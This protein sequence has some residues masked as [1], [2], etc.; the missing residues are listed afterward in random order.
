MTWRGGLYS[1]EGER[2]FARNLAEK[3]ILDSSA[4]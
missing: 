3:V 4:T 1:V 2:G